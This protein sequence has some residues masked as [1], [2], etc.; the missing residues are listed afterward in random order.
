MTQR[1]KEMLS[2]KGF[3]KTVGA[4]T[5]GA[6][7]LGAPAALWGCESRDGKERKVGTE[8]R[9]GTEQPGSRPGPNVI[10][11]ILDTLRKDHVG[12]YGN[13]WI[14]TPNLDALAGESLLFTHAH[15][16]AMPTIPAR[17][18]IHTGL[19]TWPAGPEDKFGWSPIPPE[20]TTLSEILTREGYGTFLVTDTYVQFPMN[21]KRGFGVYH[22][23]RGQEND[24]FM[25]ASSVSQE[26]IQRRYIIPSDGRNLR[27][28]LANVR[29]RKGEEDWFAPRVFSG[30]MGVL[31]EA[32]GGD[33]PFFLVADCFDPHEPWDPPEEY[34]KMYDEGYQGKEPLN[35]KYGKDDYLTDRQLSRMRALYAAEIT[36]M[37]RW[38]GRFIQR[39]H[40]LG[41]MKDTL[42]VVVSDHGHL[43]GEHGYT[44]KLGYALY[45]ELT[46]T[47]FM[48]RHPQ[49][50]GAGKTS[51]FYAST[52]DVAPTILSFL[53]VEQP[54]PM[55]GQDLMPLLAGK[56]PGR[57]R[58]HFTQGMYRYVCCRDERRVMFCRADM[59]DA[60][61]FDAVN[62]ADQR[63]NLAQAEPE[64]VRSMYE[65]YAQKDA[66]GRLPNF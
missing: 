57:A 64:T 62:D 10:L 38:L 54:E 39:A 1:K 11:I 13:D 12:A 50:K 27:Q 52:H 29:G 37:D 61:L 7:L 20:Q 16:E 51:G 44:G 2:R 31:E 40:E 30:A 42:L 56:D 45:R 19:R 23:I 21:F 41:V 36:M 58:D 59:T 48:V 22:M 17:R 65:E 66:A 6:A 46:D 49:G 14:K 43:L 60:H 34:V 28:Y 15:P 4:G 9:V 47:V 55:D 26:M 5:A 24:H 3:L 32:A 8:R 35:D 18:A 53:G 63:R 33:R 25:D